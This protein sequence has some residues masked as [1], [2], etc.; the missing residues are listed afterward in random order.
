MKV[1]KEQDEAELRALVREIDSSDD[2][3][4]EEENF[5]WYDINDKDNYFVYTTMN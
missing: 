3:E 5:A 4:N 2:D 1:L